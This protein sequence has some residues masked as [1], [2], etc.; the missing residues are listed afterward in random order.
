[1]RPPG[2]SRREAAALLGAFE[3]APVSLAMLL[4]EDLDE[5]AGTRLMVREIAGALAVDGSRG[6]GAPVV[7]AD[8]ALVCVPWR[9][10]EEHRAWLSAS[11]RRRLV[12]LAAAEIAHRQRRPC[13]QV[14]DGIRI[15]ERA[16]LPAADRRRFAQAYERFCCQQLRPWEQRCHLLR[17][18]VRTA[19]T[20]ALAA[21]GQP[22]LLDV[23]DDDCAGESACSGP[24]RLD[25]G[26]R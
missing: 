25:G 13:W 26:T 4:G 23:L 12:D 1:M 16:A 15:D 22:D 8:G 19:V 6:A 10:I 17:E 9:R 5:Q 21:V 7:A 18:R 3:D 24:S 20:E 2:L 11:T 14:P